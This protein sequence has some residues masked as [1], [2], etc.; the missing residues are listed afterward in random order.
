M[1]DEI[2]PS[3]NAVGQTMLETHVPMTFLSTVHFEGFS[4]CGRMQPTSCYTHGEL[5]LY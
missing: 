3:L 4:Y 5:C 1:Y 2:A